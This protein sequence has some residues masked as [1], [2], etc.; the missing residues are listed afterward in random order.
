MILKVNEKVND[1]YFYFRNFE[2]KF[3]HLKKF[4]SIN[5][6]GS[7]LKKENYI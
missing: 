5:F 4:H 6:I 7:K 1:I 2:S 3:T